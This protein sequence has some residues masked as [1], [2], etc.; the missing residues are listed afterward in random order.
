MFIFS[1]ESL[2]SS[3][4]ERLAKKDLHLILFLKLLKFCRISREFT[5]HGIGTNDGPLEHNDSSPSEILVLLMLI[6][7]KSGILTPSIIFDTSSFFFV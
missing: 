6:G 3:F 4:S 1:F 7:S 2:L 5:L